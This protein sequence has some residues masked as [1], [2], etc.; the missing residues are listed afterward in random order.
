[1]SVYDESLLDSYAA[2]DFRFGRFVYDAL[3]EREGVAITA[4]Y[5]EDADRD[6]EAVIGRGGVCQGA[7]EFG[8]D[9]TLSDGTLDRT[10]TTLKIF[11]SNRFPRLS[12][13]AC[14]QHK[15]HLIEP[16]QPVHHPNSACAFDHIAILAEA[17]DWNCV[18]TWLG[19]IH[20]TANISLLDGIARVETGNG[21]FLVM[22]RSKACGVYGPLPVEIAA[23]VLPYPFAIGIRVRSLNALRPY[24]AEAS[25]DSIEREDRVVVRDAGRLGGVILSFIEVQE[26]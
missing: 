22:D 14:Q 1:M 8:R 26:A 17:T 10:R 3:Q 4:L 24:L 12:N 16:A 15:R 21:C 18:L 9:V 5:S 25:L 7:I 6:A 11:R 13:F 23:P 19:T 20:G 2:G